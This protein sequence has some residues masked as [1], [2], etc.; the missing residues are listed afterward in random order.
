MYLNT[1]N[2]ESEIQPIGVT[3]VDFYAD[4]CNPCKI[5][6]PILD[7]IESNGL[8]KIIK[9]NTEQYPDIAQQ[10]SINSL[11]T[12]HFYKDGKFIEDKIGVY[13]KDKIEAI[14]DSL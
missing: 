12:M 10:H 13:P 14:I 1:N 11:P 7:K 3:I 5:L 8:A 4:W 9:V 2:L 6:S